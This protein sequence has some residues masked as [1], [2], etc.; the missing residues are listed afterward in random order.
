MLLLPD[1]AGKFIIIVRVGLVLVVFIL[2]LKLL[3][4]GL[5][6]LS[7]SFLEPLHNRLVSFF[8]LNYEK[9]LFGQHEKPVGRAR[10]ELHVDGD[11]TIAVAPT[12]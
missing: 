3:R 5:K 10:H 2:R 9:V 1:L 7:G 12:R 11:M 8:E 4:R 6:D